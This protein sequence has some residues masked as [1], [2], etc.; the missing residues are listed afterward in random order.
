[1]TYFDEA[2]V[3]VAPDDEVQEVRQERRRYV[4]LFPV[5]RS[6]ATLH[7]QPIHAV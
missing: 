7:T 2:L 1:M 3:L 5:R 4:V 6:A